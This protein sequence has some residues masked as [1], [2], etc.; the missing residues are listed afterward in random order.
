MGASLSNTYFKRERATWRNRS[1]SLLS[2]SELADAAAAAAGA[3]K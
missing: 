2:I 1:F 3:Q